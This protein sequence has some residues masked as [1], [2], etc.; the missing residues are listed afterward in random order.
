[1][2][3]TRHVATLVAL[4]GVAALPA[5]SMFGGN[6]RSQATR[7]SYPSQ[8]YAAAQASPDLSQDMIQKVQ[9][10]LQQEDVYRGNTDG[11]WGSATE[12]AVRSYQQRH[13]L[14]ATGKLDWDTLAALNL[15]P[16]QNYGSAQQ[17][18]NDQRV[19]GNDNPPPNNPPPPDNTGTQ[20][21]ANVR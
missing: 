16:N 18:P 2:T 7:S 13:N 20:N 11:V 10:R 4:C 5:C 21:P 19:G 1:M 12:S 14:N 6:N 17:P 8:S 9:G 15:G 3:R